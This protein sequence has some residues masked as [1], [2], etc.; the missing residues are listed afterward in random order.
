[1][2]GAITGQPVERRLSGSLATVLLA[3]Q[4]GAD[5]IRVHDVVESA[6]VLRM[7]QAYRDL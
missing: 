4:N 3:A 2:I 5:L 6:D 7:L 1:M